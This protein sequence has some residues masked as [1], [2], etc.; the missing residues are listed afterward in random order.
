MEKPITIRR[1]ELIANI[2]ASITISELPAFVVYD[3]LNGMTAD[4]YDAAKAEYDRDM[5]E[6]EAA[7]KETEKNDD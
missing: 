7:Q 3:V 4:M 1:E 6:Y 5:A 2:S